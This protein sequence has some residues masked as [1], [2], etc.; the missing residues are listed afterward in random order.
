VPPWCIHSY[1][2]VGGGHRVKIAQPETLPEALEL[3]QRGAETRVIGGGTAITILVR[4]RLLQPDLLVSLR[5]VPGLSG[6][7]V[8]GQRGTAV[9]GALATHR[10][11]ARHDGLAGRAPLLREV[12]SLVGNARVRNIATVGG[13]VAEADYASDPPG[14]LV[15][16]DALVRC[17]SASGERTI[18]LNDFY[19]GF[20]ATAL[21]DDELVTAVEVPLPS[22]GTGAA[23]VK[24]STRSS[25]DRPCLGATAVVRL[26]GDRRCEHLRVVVGA[27]TEVPLTRPEVERDAVGHELSSDLR[28]EIGRR[29]ADGARTL[30]DSRGS[31]DYRR[32]MIAVWVPRVLELACARAVAATGA[33]A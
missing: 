16:L 8:D 21:R 28:R 23:Y 33:A 3:L 26:D 2:A 29:Y 18:S 20:F 22:R 1:G 31:A 13:V 14:A 15:A 12:F 6:I 30:S 10:D 11:V 32:R 25:E 9:L 4:E 7:D 24:F 5:R 17:A 27:T 19:R